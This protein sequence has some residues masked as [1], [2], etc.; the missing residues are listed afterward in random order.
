MTHKVPRCLSSVALICL[1]TLGC[2]DDDDA[3]GVVDSGDAQPKAGTDSDTGG[4]TA[5]TEPTQTDTSIVPEHERPPAL[6]ALCQL[7]TYELG[8]EETGLTEITARGDDGRRPGIQFNEG[9]G[10]GGLMTWANFTNI[11]EGVGRWEIVV[12]PYWTSDLPSDAGIVQEGVVGDVMRPAT[13]GPTAESP[14]L[15]NKGVEFGMVW[16]DGRW[17]PSCQVTDAQACHLD[18]AFLKV[19]AQG[20]AT[21]ELPIPEQV[22]FDASLDVAP[23]VAATSDG[24]IVSW[25]ETRESVS[26]LMAA[27]LDEAGVPIS[28]QKLSDDQREVEVNSDAAI[29]ANDL[30][31][32]AVWA[33][34]GRDNLL[35]RAWDHAS[36]AP[37]PAPRLV[38]NEFEEY[39]NAKI[40]RG[41][42]RFLVSWASPIDGDYEI[43]TQVLDA[44]GKPTGGS[45]R[46]TFT[47]VDVSSSNIAWN[48][49]SFAVV[50]ESSKENGVATCAVE[51]CSD[52]VFASLVG[53]DGA[54]ISAPVQFSSNINDSDNAV[55]SWDGVGWTAVWQ[56]LG[57]NRWRIVY[58]QM[59][60]E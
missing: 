12:A 41:G 44:S 6:P 42:N 57:Q 30:R 29:A 50:W 7:I 18:V 16:Q 39:Y 56:L 13:S 25:V 53:L 10:N 36:A 1:I 19:D 34:K 20:T 21:G 32:V 37:E 23:A 5:A 27:R 33:P 14:S 22:T 31:A 40:V 4:G 48:G 52:Q 59:T 51:E 11:E 17:D 49:T 46:V 9:T 43:F 24:Y 38:N 45:H 28:T 55:I 54:P 15:A 3:K 26:L 8:G 35:V 47:D 58:G 60:C 2:S